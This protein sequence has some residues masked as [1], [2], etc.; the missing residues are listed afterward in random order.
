MWAGDAQDE[1]FVTVQEAAD[2]LGRSIATI[3]RWCDSG[4]LRAHKVG[5]E[6]LVD[7]DSVTAH[8]PRRSKPTGGRPLELGTSLRHVRE[9]DLRDR[10]ITIPDVLRYQDALHDADEVLEGARRA[11]DGVA[12]ITPAIEVDLPKSSYFTRTALVLPL[13]DRVAY[14]AVIASFADR[15]DRTLLPSVFGGR[16]DPSNRAFL[17]DGVGDWHAWRRRVSE[18]LRAGYEWMVKT[19][20]TAYFD[21]MQH[22]LLYAS[23]EAFNP[24]PKM[25]DALRRML[26]QWALVP[27]VGIPQGPNASRFLQNVFTSPIDH[28]MASGPWLYFRYVDDIRILGKTR[29][30]VMSGLQALERECRRRALVLSAQK[31]RLLRGRAAQKDFESPGFREAQYHVDTGDFQQ[32]RLALRAILK[33]ALREETGVEVR[34]L[35]FSVWRLLILRDRWTKDKLIERMHDLAPAAPLVALFLRPWLDDEPTMK[36]LESF[37]EDPDRNASP[38]LTAWLIAAMLE[39][40]RTMS[41]GAL[42]YA[43]RITQDRNQP[44]YL[45]C[46]T[47][48]MLALG[49]M[50]HDI[51]WIRTQ[52]RSEVDP[53][54]ARAYLVALARTGSLDNTSVSRTVGRI[55]GLARTAAYL[56]GR[57]ALP[58]LVHAAIEVPILS[59][60]AVVAR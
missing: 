12:P 51:E 19:D 21:T 37:F 34:P 40:K 5:K 7:R 47:A 57:Q 11:L 54:L 23:I 2:Q 13:E 46:L 22:T 10:D 14:Q 49:H 18:E 9:V 6:W 15:A 56:K 3:R 48:N 59:R 58:S 39:K 45:R 29:G 16:R 55:P 42:A 50:T 4:R 41:P 36:R 26:R 1:P 32:A 33:E 25:M 28:A 24:D 43:R 44:S 31:T 20:V 17:K 52:L 8:R 30:D 27:G 35:R 60:E 38:P 53:P